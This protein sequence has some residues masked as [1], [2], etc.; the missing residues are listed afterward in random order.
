MTIPKLLIILL[1][2]GLALAYDLILRTP[3]RQELALLLLA[4]VMLALLSACAP[5]ST[6][7]PAEVDPGYHLFYLTPLRTAVVLSTGPI[8][9]WDGDRAHQVS[10]LE[11]SATSARITATDWIDRSILLDD[12]CSAEAYR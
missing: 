1:V 8:P 6:W 3:R 4:A 2:A 7:T 11:C 10:I 5:Q 9:A 12:L